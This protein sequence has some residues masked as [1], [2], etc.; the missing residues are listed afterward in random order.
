M[1]RMKSLL[2]NGTGS[3]AILKSDGISHLLAKWY[4]HLIGNPLCYAHC[5]YPPGLSTSNTAFNTP[6]KFRQPLGNLQ[7]QKQYHSH[8]YNKI[9]NCWYK[10]HSY[11]CSF[12][13][14][15]FPYQNHTLTLLH[16]LNK[17]LIVFPYWKLLPLL[18]YLPKL[19]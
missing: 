4:I 16:H 12:P 14:A 9:N 11:L 6:T 19:G 7:A 1:V 15:C 10:K 2:Q 5:C 3:T 8:C 13:T 17:L 18:Q